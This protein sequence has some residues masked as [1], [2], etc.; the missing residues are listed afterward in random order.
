[1]KKRIFLIFKKLIYNLNI[2][3]MKYECKTCL[4]YT[5]LKPNYIRHISTKKHKRNMGELDENGIKIPY[6]DST[7]EHK[8]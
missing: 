7:N 6:Q 4:F 3:I 8:F 2:G 1:M 5:D